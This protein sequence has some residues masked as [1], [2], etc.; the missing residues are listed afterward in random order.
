[1][2][3]LSQEV[4]GR[5]YVLGT[6]VDA[7][8][9]VAGSYS[10][11]DYH[12]WLSGVASGYGYRVRQHGALTII[13][14]P[15]HTRT[16]ALGESMAS[17]VFPGSQA[18]AEVAKELLEEQGSAHYDQTSELVTATGPTD[19]IE[20]IVGL[21]D[22]W[23]EHTGGTDGVA[24]LPLRYAR[25]GDI[26]EAIKKLDLPVA[27]GELNAHKLAVT[28][29]EA[30]IDK[31]RR[32]VYQADEAAESI[33]VRVVVFESTVEAAVR[34]ATAWSVDNG[35]ISG[36]V[37]GLSPNG[38]GGATATVVD[39]LNA[40]SVTALRKDNDVTVVSEP[41]IMVAPGEDASVLVGEQ[42]PVPG[43]R[44]ITEDGREIQSID[45][46]NVG[47]SVDLN[48]RRYGDDGFRSSIQVE[49]SEVRE[50]LDD[51][52]GVVIGER[53]IESVFTS[54]QC[55]PVFLGGLLSQRAVDNTEGIP[56]LVQP[57]RT[58]VGGSSEE[59]LDRRYLGMAIE[60]S[61]A[62]SD[63][64][65]ALARRAGAPE[66]AV[67]GFQPRRKAKPGCSVL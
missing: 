62:G 27:V 46:Q 66:E 42:V 1:M 45:R 44:E 60:V 48:T 39:G 61:E 50:A 6:G 9:T 63:C 4:D 13:E 33:E 22:Q 54:K 64:A 30:D 36:Q 55:Q 28:G 20:E 16:S 5:Q 19:L 23:T 10:G 7:T 65:S 38:V 41:Q 53:S 34:Y 3:V 43:E 59:T 49:I 15:D 24:V 35:E 17:V 2:E 18:V 57:L 47:V 67:E 56:G 52:L 12:K 29:L 21:Q 58:V 37:S 31:V 8:V 51:E 25:S 26:V 40:A 32:V 14:N 11:T